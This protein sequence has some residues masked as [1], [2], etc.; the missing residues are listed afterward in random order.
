M[1]F[2]SET[3]T[4]LFFPL[5]RTRWQ[6]LSRD[7]SPLTFRRS[8]GKPPFWLF[9]DHQTADEIVV[10]RVDSRRQAGGDEFP[11]EGFPH[12]NATAR[13]VRR[14]EFLRVKVAGNVVLIWSRV[15]GKLPIFTKN[16]YLWNS[17]I[18]KNFYRLYEYS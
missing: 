14:V 12:H 5:N 4:T 10:H 17:K 3:L 16:M 18:N 9:F 15:P 11:N 2:L 1:S 8:Q 7:I 13:R 6:E